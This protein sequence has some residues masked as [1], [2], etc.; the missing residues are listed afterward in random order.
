MVSNGEE[1]SAVSSFLRLSFTLTPQEVMSRISLS[2]LSSADL[3][4]SVVHGYSLSEKQQS[5][6]YVNY[7]SIVPCLGGH[8][9][10]NAIN[11]HCSLFY[12]T[13]GTN[14]YEDWDRSAH[15]AYRVHSPTVKYHPHLSILLPNYVLLNTGTNHVANTLSVE[16]QHFNF[17][18]VEYAWWSGS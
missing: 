9:P 13:V 7:L 10:A 16:G 5:N 6:P 14:P 15:L 8:H 3:T 12:A 4:L 2:F 18:V 1:G 17:Q 11:F